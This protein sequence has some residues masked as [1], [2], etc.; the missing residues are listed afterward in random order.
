MMD[1]QAQSGLPFMKMHGAGNDFV[2]IDSRGRGPVM[3]AGLAIT[4]LG[5]RLKGVQWLAILS[6]G[7]GVAILTFDA[8]RL[9]VLALG[10]TLTWGFYAYFKKSLPIGPN[11][12]FAL[13]V[14]VLL[15]PA[16]A[17][18][19]W[20]AATGRMQFLHGPGWQSRF[21]PAAPRRSR[22]PACAR[23]HAPGCRG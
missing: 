2:V 5:E 16:I 13:E 1:T 8:G 4:L 9:P 20:F 3:T 10:L 19:I 11:Q 12:G 21:R 23:T 14:L 6:A 17:V 18:I 22:P 15:L 7:I